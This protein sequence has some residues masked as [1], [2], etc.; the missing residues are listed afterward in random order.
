M[1]SWHYNNDGSDNGHMG[2]I[3]SS[4][5]PSSLPDTVQLI[6]PSVTDN[7]IATINN[8]AVYC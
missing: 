8:K 2:L 7:I 6:V 1:V 5:K 3:S 4:T